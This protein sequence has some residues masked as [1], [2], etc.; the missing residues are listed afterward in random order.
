MAPPR[1]SEAMVAPAGLVLQNTLRS[2]VLTGERL[3]SETAETRAN[4]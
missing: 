3:H 1:G 4:L 2:V